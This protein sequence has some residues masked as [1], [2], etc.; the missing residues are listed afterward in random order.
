M[1]EPLGSY[2]HGGPGLKPEE[3]EDGD[4]A[5]HGDGKKGWSPADGS[6]HVHG[7]MGSGPTKDGV[8][9]VAGQMWKDA[10]GSEKFYGTAEAD[11]GLGAARGY[12]Q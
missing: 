5:R 2:A 6:S 7:K 1:A 11:Y 10:Y 8:H 12:P 9:L 4:Q 3:E